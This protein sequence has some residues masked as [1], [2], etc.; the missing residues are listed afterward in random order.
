MTAGGPPSSVRR[1]PATLPLF[2][3]SGALLLPRG[4]LPLNIFE[5]R[6]VRMVEDA[7][8]GERLIGMVQPREADD[9]AQ[10]TELF[11]VGCAGR[12]S[13]CAETED[14]RYLVTLL[15]VCRF[16]VMDEVAADSLYR[17]ARV[18][19]APFGADLSL[20]LAG[21]IG[22][23]RL[24]AALGAYVERNRIEMEWDAVE[25]LDDEALVTALAMACPFEPN[26][27]QALLEAADTVERARALTA[28]IEMASLTPATAAGGPRQ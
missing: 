18:S 25:D 6:Y 3:L 26:E 5:P 20:A 23:G 11:E 21:D 9:R 13:A 28:L 8:E 17:R 27:K 4:R 2:P 10:R 14:G 1:L 7:L 22:R 12:I 15:G 24:L 16:R 19:F